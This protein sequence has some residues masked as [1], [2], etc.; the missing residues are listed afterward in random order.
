MIMKNNCRSLFF[1]LPILALLFSCHP[2]Y[3]ATVEELDI[4]ITQYDEEQDFSKLQTFYLADSIIYI[5]D[6]E[7]NSLINVSHSHEDDI[8][9]LVRQNFLDLGWTEVAGPTNGQIDADVSIVLSVLETDVN[10][11]YDYWWDWWYWYPWDWWYPWYS[12]SYWHPG[13]PIWPGYPTYP[14]YGYTVG[15]LFID[16]LNMDAVIE[17]DPDDNSFKVPMP[18]KGSAIGILAG[19]DSY[20]QDRLTKEINQVFEQSPYLQK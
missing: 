12:E 5:N 17:P 7:S 11:Y 1:L 20:I 6:E 18:W 19:S 15:T 10:F 16:M 4:A 13:Y 8:L 2:E 14:S 3:D 9:S